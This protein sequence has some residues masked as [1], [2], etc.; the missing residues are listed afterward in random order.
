MSM[1]IKL[2]SR[3]FFSILHTYLNVSGRLLVRR[4]VASRAGWEPED[5]TT[6]SRPEVWKLKRTTS[7]KHTK[8]IKKLWNMGIEIQ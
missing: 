6:W 5:L 3:N 1:L 8:S 2:S 7:G 4:A